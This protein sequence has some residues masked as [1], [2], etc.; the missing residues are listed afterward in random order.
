MDERIKTPIVLDYA[1][2]PARPRRSM[3][4]MLVFGVAVLVSGGFGFSLLVPRFGPRTSAKVPAAKS[5]V[6]QSSTYVW[7]IEEFHARLDTYPDVLAD[8]CE[9]PSAIDKEDARWY[10]FLNDCTVVD[11]WGNPLVY[12]RRADGY[13]LISCGPDGKLGTNDDIANRN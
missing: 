11:P 8:L 10:Q 7:A 6:G 12:R 4:G 13:D 2:Q 1:S 3:Q 9:R 5:M